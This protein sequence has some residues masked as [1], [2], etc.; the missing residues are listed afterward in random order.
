HPYMANVIIAITANMEA[1]TAKNEASVQEVNLI[2]SSMAGPL[3]AIGDSFFWGTLRPLAAFIGV[4]LVILFSRVFNNA[5]FDYGIIIPL[6]FLILY[7][8]VHIPV[9]YWFMFAGF[10]LDKE[11]IALLSKFE[12]KHLGEIVRYT[13]FAVVIASIILYFTVFGFGIVNGNG[14]LFRNPL[15]DAFIFAVVLVLSFILSRL[16]AAFMIYLIVLAC[17]AMSYLGL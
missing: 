3:A 4:F 10:K 15:P 6:S 7:N 5:D 12:F 14:S 8:T 17:I 2:K 11:S 16:S 13:V 1:K 9:R